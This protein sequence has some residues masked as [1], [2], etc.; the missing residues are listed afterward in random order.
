MEVISESTISYEEMKKLNKLRAINNR[1]DYF[2]SYY[3]NNTKNKIVFCNICNK[4]M[5]KSSLKYHVEKS[6]EHQINLNK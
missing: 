3:E 4:F 2:K 6:K 5:L 1:K